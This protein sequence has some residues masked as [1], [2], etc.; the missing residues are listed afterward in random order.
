MALMVDE[1]IP[2]ELMQQIR[3]IHGLETAQMV[4]L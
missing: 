4:T 2:A 1:P 3:A